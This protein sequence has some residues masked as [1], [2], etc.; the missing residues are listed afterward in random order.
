MATLFKR[1]KKWYISYY[2]Y[3]KQVKRAISTDRRI[4]E[5]VLADTIKRLDLQK[6]RIENPNISWEEFVEKY[7][8]Y[9]KTNKRPKSV[10]RDVATIKIFTDLMKP[11]K[12]ASLTPQMFEDYKAKRVE[13]GVKPSSVKRELNTLKNM[14]R[15]AYEW[16]Y[17]PENFS[18]QIK[19][20]K[21][22]NQAKKVRFF[23]K[24]EIEKLL[25]VSSETVKRIILIGL[26]TGFRIG[27]I[28]NL[29]WD[30]ID[31]NRKVA[32]VQAKQDWQPKDNDL[33]EV[34]LKD[35]FVKTL[36]EWKQNTKSQYV[37]GKKFTTEQASSLF[38]KYA[39]LAGI[40]DASAHILRH[41]FASYLAMAGVDLYTIA[42]LLGHSNISTTQIYA[43]LL[44]DILRNAVNK[45]PF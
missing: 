9:S 23:S 34:P 21:D 42:K 36:K 40:T 29:T 8:S 12:V 17:L 14:V 44:P 37:L 16:G 28:V 41:T 45:L 10:Q 32:I 1:G 5:R 7:L 39:R 30:D 18:S 43:H 6:F 27:E 26:N 35:N 31:F 13:S 24:E 33:R 20:L 3:G 4:A 11:I 22:S 38:R 2:L 25:K 15:K 19:K